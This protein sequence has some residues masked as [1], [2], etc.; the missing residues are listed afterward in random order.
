MGGLALD[1]EDFVEFLVALRATV[2][3][4]NGGRCTFAHF[5]RQVKQK[6]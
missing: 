2:L 6:R 1:L 4:L 3:F 5:L